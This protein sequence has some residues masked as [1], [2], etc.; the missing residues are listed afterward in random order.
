MKRVNR[1]TESSRT[2]SRGNSPGLANVRRVGRSESEVPPATQPVHPVNE[3][4]AGSGDGGA[5]PGPIHSR[6]L[7]MPSQRVHHRRTDHLFSGD[8]PQ[9]LPGGPPI[10]PAEQM[11][12]P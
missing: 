11:C 6:T 8:S 1:E 2:A 12:L 5:C 10:L 4:E 9:R 7:P 3:A